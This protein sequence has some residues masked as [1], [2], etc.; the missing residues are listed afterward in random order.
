MWNSGGS[1][2]INVF[3]MSA[4]CTQTVQ[5]DGIRYLTISYARRRYKLRE[6]SRYKN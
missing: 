2:V 3:V 5:V 1:E 4:E 6:G